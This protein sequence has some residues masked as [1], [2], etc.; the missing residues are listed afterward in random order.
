M[1]G[2]CFLTF[3]LGASAMPAMDRSASAVVAPVS[4]LEEA[5]TPEEEVEEV[6]NQIA[7][8]L[9]VGTVFASAIGNR[10]SRRIGPGP[11]LVLGV[12]ACSSGWLLP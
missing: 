6:F 12:A 7:G 10:L 8:A 11:C 5:L 3:A 9:G 1:F 4:H 2:R